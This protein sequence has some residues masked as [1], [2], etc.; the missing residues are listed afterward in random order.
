MRPG[1][2]L[3]GAVGRLLGA[4]RMTEGGIQELTGARILVK[5]PAGRAGAG[6]W[7]S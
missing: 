1:L 3:V 7:P 6:K 2:R 4:R 5:V